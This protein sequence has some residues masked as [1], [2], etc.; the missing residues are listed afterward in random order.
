GVLRNMAQ[1]TR[2]RAYPGLVAKKEILQARLQALLAADVED[3]WRTVLERWLPDVPLL[4]F[5][6]CLEALR[7]PASWLRRLCLAVR[8]SQRTE[9]LGI[10]WSAAAGRRFGSGEAAPI[11]SGV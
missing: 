5:A 11:Q 7:Q 10:F 3:G 1:Y 2:L 9:L 4:L 6:E 8:L